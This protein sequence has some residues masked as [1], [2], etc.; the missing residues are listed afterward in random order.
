MGSHFT[1]KEKIKSLSGMGETL[2]VFALVMGDLF[3]GLF[4][5]TEAAAV[6]VMG[7][8]V[9][10]VIRRQLTWQRFV[11]ALYETLKTSCMVM[12]LVGW[13]NCFWKISSCNTNTI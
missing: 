3:Y 8:L 9:V 2:S 5:P 12:M 1:W 4:T 7:V 10:S 13:C 11:D 6:G